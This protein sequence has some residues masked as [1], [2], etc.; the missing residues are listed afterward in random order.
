MADT[1]AL[2]DDLRAEGDALD[3]LVAGLDSDQWARPTPAAGWTIAHQIAHLAWTDD[4]ATEAATA[5]EAFAR[6]VEK[7]RAEPERFV[8]AGAEQGAAEPPA[9]LL[10]RWRAGRAALLDLLAAQPEGV[11]LP[12]YGPPMGAA[13]MAT[14][15]LMETWAHGQDVADALDVWR[16]P[17]ARLRHV[18]H[19]G[20]RARDYA[21]LVRQLPQPVEEFRVELVAPG[22]TLWT[23]GPPGAAQRVTGRALD[24]CLLVTQRAHRDDLALRAEGPDARRWLEIAQAFAGPPGAGRPAGQRAAA[25]TAGGSGGSSDRAVGQP[26]WPSADQP[27]APDATQPAGRMAHEPAL[28]PTTQ[29]ADRMPSPAATRP[30]G[31]E[32]AGA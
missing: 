1:A 21:Y 27:P 3:A 18:A 15:R 22:G 12:W 32:G 25:A 7:S 23:Y 11:K 10:A 8:A 5:P 13:S 2:L 20:V 19:I 30:D 4:R 31:Q 29:P 6:E 16:A 26:T 14:A 9:A 24:F 17:T 28:P